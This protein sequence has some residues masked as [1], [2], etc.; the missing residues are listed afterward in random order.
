MSKRKQPATTLIGK[1]TV[2]LAVPDFCTKVH[3]FWN[4]QLLELDLPEK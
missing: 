2:A 3:I 4:G 1:E